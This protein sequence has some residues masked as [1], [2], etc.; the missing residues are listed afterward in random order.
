MSRHTWEVLIPFFLNSLKT[1]LLNVNFRHWIT[2]LG[3]QRKRDTKDLRNNISFPKGEE[4]S[5]L[6]L[7]D[8]GEQ[9]K[10]KK[11]LMS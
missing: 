1:L 5:Y 6:S 2:D 3:N 9:K 11:F 7:A 10:E 4:I 8:P